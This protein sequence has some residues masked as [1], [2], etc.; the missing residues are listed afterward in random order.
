MRADN[1]NYF[2]RIV[3]RLK[4]HSEPSAAH[5]DWLARRMLAVFAEARRRYETGRWH[6]SRFVP[7]RKG[8]LLAGRSA[9]WASAVVI[10]LVIA[11]LT[12]QLTVGVVA[13]VGSLLAWLRP[14]AQSCVSW[15]EVFEHIHSACTVSY[16]VSVHTAEQPVRQFTVLAKI[17]GRRRIIGPDAV[18]IVSYTHG[19]VLTLTPSTKQAQ[20]SPLAD[21]P[22]GDLLPDVIAD[23]RALSPSAGQNATRQP[24]GSKADAVDVFE[25]SRPGQL[26]KI[27]ADPK[28]AKPVRIEIVSQPSGLTRLL[29]NLQWNLPLSEDLFI[30]AAHD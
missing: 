3:S 10:A 27:W 13:G 28:T 16:E 9:R 11:A 4:I 26:W 5:R 6:R 21:V 14:P 2:A 17:P 29:T 7:W 18:L 25:I 20:L 8:G 22:P 12:L 19:K 24:G 23:L 30:L 1:E 15:A